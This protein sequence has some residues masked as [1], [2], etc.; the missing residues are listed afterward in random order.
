M[1][2][3]L[4]PS[5]YAVWFEPPDE[6]GDEALHIVSQRLTL[7]L[8]GYAFREFCERVVP[9]L[10]GTRTLEE[11]Q[12]ATADVFRGED[13]AQTV[14]L[15]AGQG[16]IVEAGERS[17]SPAEAERLTPQLN[18]FHEL[19][20]GADLQARLAASS[21]AI[22]G[23]GGAGATVALALAAAGVGTLRCHDVGPV[24][25]AD[26][27][28]APPLGLG[29]VGEGRAARVAELAGAAAP[30]VQ[31]E[32]SAAALES[33]DDVRAAIAGADFVVSC[34]DPSQS[35][36][37]FKLNRV[38]LA[39][40]RRWIA[41]APAGAEVVVGPAIHP[42][43]SACYLCYRM[44]AVACAADPDGAF[45]FERYLDRRRADDGPRG[46]TLVFAAGLAG[47]LVASEV[48]K[49]L[50]GIA[51]PSLVGRILTVRLTDLVVERHAVLRKPGCPACGPLTG[52]GV[53]D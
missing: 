4:L 29:A 31:V 48:V 17:L 46:E 32:A 18:L 28:H 27:Y 44:R 34:L 7:K 49:E 50:T 51:E 30:D 16:V 26:V 9:L 2:R 22:L 15:L 10:D 5:H 42:G 38:C 33:E 12:T 24:V 52:A 19:A 35:N 20:P 14:A 45:A 8:K 40:D 23:L 1:K 53:G 13:L 41:C 11:I 3:L 39:D 36:L 37:V 25:A 21:V 47:N 6:S 43:R